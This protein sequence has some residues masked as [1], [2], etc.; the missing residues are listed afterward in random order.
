M[1]DTATDSRDDA[2]WHRFAELARAYCK[3]IETDVVRGRPGLEVIQSSLIRLYSAASKLPEV[4]NSIERPA[5]IER[6][7]WNNVYRGL[8]ERFKDFD[9]YWDAFNPLKKGE[10]DPITNSLADD[11]A[12]IWRDLAAGLK[13]PVFS[14]EELRGVRWEWR[15]TFHVH[16]GAHAIGALR[17]MHYILRDM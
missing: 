16:W 15:F 14:V 4:P 10:D 3:L 1:N 7:S 2:Q 13:S 6:N 17:A 5:R 9:T 8:Q 12:D 11:L